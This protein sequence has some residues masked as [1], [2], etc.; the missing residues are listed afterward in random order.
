MLSL[1]IKGLKYNKKKYLIVGLLSIVGFSFIYLILQLL[2]YMNNNKTNEV[3]DGFSSLLI[4]FIVVFVVCI[5][6]SISIVL[7][8]FYKIRKSDIYILST[9]G[10]TNKTIKKIF[11]L[12]LIF[13]NLIIIIGSSIVGAIIMN[14][15]KNKYESQYTF[16]LRMFLVFFILSII[17]FMTT[18]MIQ[19]NKI[20]KELNIENKT[21]PKKIG[22]QNLYQLKIIRRVF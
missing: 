20:F 9:I 4:V 17:L 13:L 12:E 21:K 6:M 11:I 7:Y 16:D 1:S 18:G 8:I 19:I 10:A 14:I 3:D 2:G 22:N 5:Y 15:F